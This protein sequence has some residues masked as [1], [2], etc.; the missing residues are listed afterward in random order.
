MR[1]L[2]WVTVSITVVFI[3]LLS[4]AGVS[5]ADD[6]VCTAT[7]TGDLFTMLATSFNSFLD[8]VFAVFPFSLLQWAH[9]LFDSMTSISPESPAELSFDFVVFQGVKPFEFLDS[10]A[11]D[12]IMACFRWMMLVS[13]LFGLLKHVLER[14]L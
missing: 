5:F 9:D 13:V 4:F 10:G 2:F 3:F 1:N 8:P 7:S 6:F 12:V 14:I 11:F